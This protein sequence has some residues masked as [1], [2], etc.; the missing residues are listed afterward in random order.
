MTI[1][2]NPNNVFDGLFQ[3][4]MALNY[5][6]PQES[7][8]QDMFGPIYHGTT[9]EARNKIS[10]EGY[11]IQI[12]DRR[13]GY[14]TSD[15]YGGIPAPIHHL[16]Y[17]VYFTTSKNIAKMYNENSTKGLNEIYL[18]SQNILTINFGASSTMM[19]W[20]Q[21]NGYDMK[22]LSYYKD[23]DIKNWRYEVEKNR[24]QS[25]HNLT[26]N[27]SSQYDAVWYK[28]KGM[29]RLL[30]GDQICV[31]KPE[32]LYAIDYSL[33][34]EGE[35]GSKVEF[36][37]NFDWNSII[38]ESVPEE[39]IQ[40]YIEYSKK[41]NFKGFGPAGGGNIW[42]VILNKRNIPPGFHNGREYC[43]EV[44]WNKGGR[45]LNLYEDMIIPYTGKRK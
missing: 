26:N 18:N 11:S 7:K 20:W 36:N 43:Y 45:S 19:K 37:P 3:T 32:L 16:G 31:Y 25:T 4:S 34:Q 9:E 23:H 41:N 5:I 38:D 28:G 21:Q 29:F 42:G 17:G 40:P 1:L 14:E 27:L 15:Y 12:D 13:N 39:N 10:E 24:I 44:K 8:D 35:I 30:D 33:S 6:S 2:I 22:P